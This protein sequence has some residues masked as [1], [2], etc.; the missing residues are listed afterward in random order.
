MQVVERDVLRVR[1]QQIRR[2]RRHLRRTTVDDDQVGRIG[3]LARSAVGHRC[4]HPDRTS[5]RVCYRGGIGVG[6]DAKFLLLRESDV[7]VDVAFGINDEGFAG[8][9]AEVGLPPLSIP[10]YRW[11]P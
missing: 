2:G 3:E 1:G 6:G 10:Q 9:L 8:A 4:R 7:T 11:F 5:P